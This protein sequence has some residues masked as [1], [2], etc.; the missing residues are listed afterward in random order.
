MG[1]WFDFVGRYKGFDFSAQLLYAHGGKV[2]NGTKMFAYGTGRHK[3]MYYAFSESNTDS[4]IP[5]VRSSSEHNNYRSWSDYYL[6]DADYLRVRGLTLG[7]TFKNL[8]N[9]NVE[10]VRIYTT[11][12]NPF[13]FTKYEGYDPEVGASEGRPFDRGLDIGKYPIARTFT[14]GVQ[15]DF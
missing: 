3:D 4:N 12:Q 13:T 10:K 5:A 2:Y 9:S 1:S 8:L 7:Y 6:E 15:I 11:A 14:A